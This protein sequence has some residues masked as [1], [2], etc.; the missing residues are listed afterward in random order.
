MKNNNVTELNPT[1]LRE[2]DLSPS[3][4]E[5][6]ETSHRIRQILFD[7]AAHSGNKV[8]LKILGWL[9]DEL[10]FCQQE[11]WGFD[12]DARHHRF[13]DLPGCTCPK[14]DNEDRL[15]HRQAIYDKSCPV[16]GHLAGAGETD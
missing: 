2:Q 4:I 7:L 11:I 13:F 16:H 5:A 6:L 3:H 12:Q 10:E 1:L 15:G 8:E 9:F 14:S